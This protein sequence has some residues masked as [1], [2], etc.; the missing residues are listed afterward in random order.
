MTICLKRIS[1]V[2]VFLLVSGCGNFSLGDSRIEGVVVDEATS[3][4]VIGAIVI[5]QWGGDVR[6]IVQGSSICYHS[7]TALTDANGKFVIPA[8]NRAPL[9]HMEKAVTDKKRHIVVYM[10]GFNNRGELPMMDGKATIRIPRATETGEK[11][12]QDIGVG[13]SYGCGFRDGSAVSLDQLI[14]RGCAEK[15]ALLKQMG[16]PSQPCGR[17]SFKRTLEGFK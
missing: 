17:L 11:R 16:R 14:E 4:P 5:A 6:G 7:E 9:D 12:L 3:K 1:V 8:W 15:S 13:V 2:L 10:E